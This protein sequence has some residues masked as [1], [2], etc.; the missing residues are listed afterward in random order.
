LYF[1]SLS[2]LDRGL[3]DLLTENAMRTRLG[4]FA[5]DPLSRGKLDGTRFARSIADRRP[6]TPPSSIRELQREFDP[7]LG[8]GFLTAEGR[9]TLAQ[10][11]LQFVL[12]WPWVCSALVPL[13]APERLDELVRTES[14]PPLSDA[15]VERLLSFSG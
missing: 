1:G 4:F 14:V 7:V 2:P 10:G 3:L 5:H 6:D 13:P 11:T 9:R 15:E 12:R 8:L